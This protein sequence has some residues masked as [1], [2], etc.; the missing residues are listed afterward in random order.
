MRSTSPS[1]S[2]GDPSPEGI[3]SG[4]ENKEGKKILDSFLSPLQSPEGSKGMPSA[5]PPK[6]SFGPSGGDAD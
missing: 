2:G 3:P 5:D 4:L 1:A 6:E